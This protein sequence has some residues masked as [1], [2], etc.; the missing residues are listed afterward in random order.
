MQEPTAS[1]PNRAWRPPSPAAA[2]PQPPGEGDL[3]VVGLVGAVRATGFDGPWC[4]E[5]H[6]PDLR[7]LPVAEAAER[8]AAAATA[9]LDAAAE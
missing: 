9:I 2:S 1:P 5:V 8:A 3:D 6:P 4:V 7:A